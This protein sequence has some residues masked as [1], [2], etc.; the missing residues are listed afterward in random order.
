MKNSQISELYFVLNSPFRYYMFMALS[1]FGGWNIA[2]DVM[3][4]S[5][6]Q[7]LTTDIGGEYMIIVLL[8]TIGFYLVRK[9]A[10]KKIV[11]IQKDLDKN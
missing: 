8:S 6:K 1:L 4:I 11:Q 3:A 10:I 2:Q 7:L 9:N 5:N